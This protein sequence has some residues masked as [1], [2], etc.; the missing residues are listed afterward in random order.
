LSYEVLN[1]FN[2]LN[3]TLVCRVDA[4]KTGRKI[5]HFCLLIPIPKI[6]D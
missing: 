6:L 3:L 2:L 1:I 4:N 5:T